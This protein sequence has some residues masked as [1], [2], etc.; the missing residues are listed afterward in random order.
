MADRVIRPSVN[1]KTGKEYLIFPQSCVQDLPTFI[2]NVPKTYVPM[3]RTVNGHALSANITLTKTDV[4][5]GNVDNVKQYSASNPP[6]YPVTSVAGKTGAVTLSKTDVGLGNVPNVNCQNASNLTSGTVALARL[7]STLLKNG[8]NVTVTH[9]SDGTWTISASGGG[10]TTPYVKTATVTSSGY[11]I[12]AST[13][14]KG[15]YPQVETY[16]G[17]ERTYEDYTVDASGNVKIMTAYS[18]S[19]KIIIR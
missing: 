9:N 17:T 2:S 15:A 16:Q 11:T 18:V 3:T 4:G 12:D 14:G 6:P 1:T 13:H 8:T 7:P 19:L 10:S 5:L